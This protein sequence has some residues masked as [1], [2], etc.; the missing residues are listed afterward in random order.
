[1]RF[2][3][4]N[5]N[6]E[7]YTLKWLITLILLSDDYR[8]KRYTFIYRL[9]SSFEV[10]DKLLWQLVEFHRRQILPSQ[11]SSPTHRSS[12]LHA[13]LHSKMRILFIDKVNSRKTFGSIFLDIVDMKENRFSS[14]LATHFWKQI[15]INV[16]IETIKV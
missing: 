5:H 1:M 15:P 10:F 7:K 4:S 2:F 13:A 16:R 8:Y 11:I 3:L 9:H 6:E 12:L 14:I